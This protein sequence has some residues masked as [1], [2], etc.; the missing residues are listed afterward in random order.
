MSL[1]SPDV[2]NVK[3]G[4]STVYYEDPKSP[5]RFRVDKDAVPVLNQDCYTVVLA[6]SINLTALQEV[7]SLA[8]Q[9]TVDLAGKAADDL[10]RVP[11]TIKYGV[12]PSLYQ[13]THALE[14][15]AVVCIAVRDES[16]LRKINLQQIPGGKTTVYPAISSCLA[17]PLIGFSFTPGLAR[18][19]DFE[20][21]CIRTA[22]IVVNN[23]LKGLSLP[24]AVGSTVL[25]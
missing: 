21:E 1:L 3:F 4:F 17:T 9:S 15:L 19:T 25:N 8:R 6:N 20:K 18:S 22:C 5:L 24:T 10:D 14:H 16:A 12:D 7:V 23:H 2:K 11:D 13:F